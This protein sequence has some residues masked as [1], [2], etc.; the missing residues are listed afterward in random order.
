MKLEFCLEFTLNLFKIGLDHA[1]DMP[2]LESVDILFGPMKSFDP[3]KLRD[4]D[5]FDLK[6]MGDAVFFGDD[7]YLSPDLSVIP[8]DHSEILMSQEDTGDIFACVS[9]FSWCS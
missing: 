8:P 9:G 2:D 1:A 6:E 3:R 7:I 4:N 5:A